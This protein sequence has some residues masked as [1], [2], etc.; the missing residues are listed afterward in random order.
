MFVSI[1]SLDPILQ[2]LLPTFTQPSF[3]THIR[4]FLGWVMCLS[5]RTVVDLG[6]FRDAVASTAKRVAPASGNHWVVR[7]VAI[8]AQRMVRPEEQ[9]SIQYG[10]CRRPKSPENSLGGA[11]SL[12]KTSLTVQAKSSELRENAVSKVQAGPKIGCRKNR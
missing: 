5:K 7:V 8:L 12:D 1:P 11:K 2:C 3:Q 10:L 4:I 6:W 9:Q